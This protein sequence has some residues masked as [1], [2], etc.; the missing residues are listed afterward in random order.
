M[1][2]IIGTTIGLL[3]YLIQTFMNKPLI[4]RKFYRIADKFDNSSKLSLTAYGMS[5]Y[6]DAKYES[7]LKQFKKAEK[8]NKKTYLEIILAMDM[9]LSYW[10]LDRIDEA[11]KVL[12][13]LRKKYDY[14]NEK[15][16]TSL[17]YFYILKSEYD[18]AL[19]CSNKALEDEPEYAPALDNIGQVYFRKNDLE[20]AEEFFQRA[21]EH[22]NLLDSNYY[23]GLIYEIRGE[24]DKAGQYFR[25]AFDVDDSSSSTVSKDDLAEKYSEYGIESG[26]LK[27]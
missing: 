23:L 17:G 16:L 8:L 13:E 22:K 19:E 1:S 25:Q 4:A 24:R 14:I 20:K 7:A 6:N 26:E 11:I 9:A 5:L 27:K 10:K 12:E 3:G 21:L 18:K 2:K 15:I